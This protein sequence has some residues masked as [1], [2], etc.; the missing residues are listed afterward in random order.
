MYRVQNDQLLFKKEQKE[1]ER[2]IGSKKVLSYVFQAYIAQGNKISYNTPW[3]IRGFS[4]AIVLTLTLSRRESVNL[5]LMY[6][7]MS[8]FSNII[9]STYNVAWLRSQK[10]ELKKAWIYFFPFI[11][12]IAMLNV[13]P[14]LWIVP[15]SI[16]SASAWIRD[17]TEDFTVQFSSGE[18]TIEGLE[19][20]FEY[21]ITDE[22]D[23]TTRVFIDTRATTTPSIKERLNP[24]TEE[25]I[26]ITRNA[27]ELYDSSL[28]TTERQEF[29]SIPDATITKEGLLQ[30][31]ERI[32]G[33]LKYWVFAFF[34]LGVYLMY[35]IAK[36]LYVLFYSLIFLLVSK[37]TKRTWEFRQ[38]FTVS[39]FAVTLPSLV[40]LVLKYL[41]VYIPYVPTL[42][43]ILLVGMILFQRLNSDPSATIEKN[44]LGEKNDDT[45]PTSIE[46]G[47]NEIKK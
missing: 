23:T 7:P 29:S 8:F 47:N 33:G 16:S 32:T 17:N 5:F 11:F 39:L 24:E 27:I 41:G 22:N 35:L 21:T 9:Q 45:T 37:L 13:L 15:S 10:D 28:Q 36:L 12:L 30:A 4:L 6:F 25:G 20:P 34:A 14:L 42:A 19:Q 2:S 38:I 1:I 3:I 44:G 31:A 43:F 46:D 40:A 18:L 26:L